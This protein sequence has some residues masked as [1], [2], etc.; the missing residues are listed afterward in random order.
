MRLE[1]SLIEWPDDLDSGPRLLGRLSDPE[2]IETVRER[3]AA[4]RC[5]EISRLRV[6]VE[7]AKRGV[8]LHKQSSG[9]S[10]S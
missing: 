2:L 4:A 10:S 9:D 8:D 6:P 1:I 7:L 5:R 3:L